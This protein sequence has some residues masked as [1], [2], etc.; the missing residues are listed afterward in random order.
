MVRRKDIATWHLVMNC[1]SILIRR[2]LGAF[3]LELNLDP[4]RPRC[5][6]LSASYLSDDSLLEVIR[7]D[8]AIAS[9]D[10]VNAAA[11]RRVYV[12]VMRTIAAGAATDVL[13]CVHKSVSHG[14]LVV[15]KLVERTTCQI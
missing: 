4:K 5:A 8:H 14:V 1:H 10:N 3:L 9:C 6:E 2:W 12:Q 11:T 15:L 13:S 7:N